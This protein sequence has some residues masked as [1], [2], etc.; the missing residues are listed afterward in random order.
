MRQKTENTVRKIIDS[1]LWDVIKD[2]SERKNINNY[3]KA[4]E[5]IAKW[6]KD[7][8]NEHKF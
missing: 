3:R 6:L 4:S 2:Y 1:K 7:L 5:E 8:E